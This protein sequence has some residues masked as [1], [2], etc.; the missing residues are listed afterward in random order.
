VTGALTVRSGC[1][2]Q[3]RTHSRL[4]RGTYH[5]CIKRAVAFRFTAGELRHSG[6]RDMLFL[7]APGAADSF[8]TIG[9][10]YISTI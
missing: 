6:A 4:F 10:N 3:R 5:F 9:F 1:D 7:A 8:N 2:S